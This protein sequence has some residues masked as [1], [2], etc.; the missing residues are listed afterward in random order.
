MA[1]DDDY[2]LIPH[3][4]LKKIKKELKTVKLDD[5][6]ENV[7]MQRSMSKLSESLNSMLTVFSEAKRELQIEEEE[8]ELLANKIDPILQ[9]L[10]TLIDQN[11]KIAE[12]ILS[13]ADMIKKVEDK[14][15]SVIESQNTIITEVQTISE[16]DVMQ[17]ASSNIP[18][19][20]PQRQ[21]QQNF[22]PQQNFSP[23]NAF[24]PRDYSLNQNPN[25]GA[26]P[27]APPQQR[28]QDPFSQGFDSK[29]L[30][31]DPFGEMGGNEQGQNVGNLPPPP[32]SQNPNFQRESTL[33]P[34]SSGQGAPPPPPPPRK[35][36][37]FGS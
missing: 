4:E 29:D 17:Q 35:K 2:D 15:D 25:Q 31:G 5:D 22:Q 30:L 26:G 14:T 12:G 32:G 28:P 16:P 6:D 33:N 36:G 34:P 21:S 10:D 1:D 20:N 23:Q 27:N 24:A 13:L 37:F 3:S 8:K 11:E 18:S 7:G 19:Q 9:K